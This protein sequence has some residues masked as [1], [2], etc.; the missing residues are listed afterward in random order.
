ME[1]S[2]MKILVLTGSPH[3]KGTTA[4]MAD[5]FIAGAEEAGHEVMRFDTAQMNISP[6]TGC[7]HCRRNKGQC[8]FND[9]MLKINPHLL[10]T[11]AVV[12][13]S[14]LYY[15]G[16]TAQLKR[17]VDRFYAVNTELRGHSKKVYLLSAGADDED[18]I[19]HGVV[20]HMQTMCRYL[21]WQYIDGVLA[22]G[23]GVPGDL[24]NSEYLKTTR[25]M[26]YQI[27]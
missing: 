9:D 19:M 2:M 22:I 11:D 4:L 21:N 13:V 17:T 14:P 6:C 20:A 27:T 8:I 10:E 16:M 5:E 12:F 3:I 7:D 25:E 1:V 26:G 24:E 15:F 23:A 18:W